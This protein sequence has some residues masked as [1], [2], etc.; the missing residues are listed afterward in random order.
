MDRKIDT[1]VANLDSYKLGAGTASQKTPSLHGYADE[2]R[3]KV[4]RWLSPLNTW[5]IHDTAAN[6]H[7]KGT[8]HWFVESTEFS[9]WLRSD[10]SFLWLTGS[11]K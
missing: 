10:S 7:C 2:E 9:D 4:L 6:V 3:Q 11:R 1:I 8:G 5:D